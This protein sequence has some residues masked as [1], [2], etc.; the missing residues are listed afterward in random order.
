MNELKYKK[1]LHCQNIPKI[2]S[3][4]CRKRQNW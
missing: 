4:N 2:Q 1:I 3:I